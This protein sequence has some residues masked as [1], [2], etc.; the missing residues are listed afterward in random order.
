VTNCL[1][2]RF[3][4]V[5]LAPAA[6]LVVA[7]AG[8]GSGGPVAVSP[9]SPSGATAAICR[10]LHA[11]LPAKVDGLTEAATQ[12]ASQ[13][14]AAWGDPAVVLRCGVARPQVLTPGTPTYDP[15]TDVLSVNNVSWLPDQ[16]SSGYTF[17]TSD[18]QAFI[19]VTVPAQYAPEVNP[20]TDLAAAIA[21]ADP[22]TL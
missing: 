17:T 1:P 14:T 11:R 15:T 13:Y 12:P 6:A 2:A 4:P 21:K 8:C 10:A 18:R 5:L 9:P 7:V 16:L 22:T 20:L 3:R 19:E